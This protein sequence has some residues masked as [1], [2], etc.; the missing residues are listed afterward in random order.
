MTAE[1]GWSGVTMGAVADRAG[2]SRQTVHHE[3]GTK[4]GLAEAMVEHELARFLA[5]VATAFDDHPDDAVAG[6]RGASRGVLELARDN[7]LLVAVVSATHG[8]D[9][10]LLPLLTTRSESL[11][12]AAT[13]VVGERLSA[14][15]LG[16]EPERLDA[17]VDM[18]VN[19]TV[20]PSGGALATKSAAITP[21]APGLASTITDCP[22]RCCSFSA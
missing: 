10:E 7:P 14:Y 20:W 19:S 12:A 11:V 2:V 18:V 9:T 17:T 3:V 21:L 22:Q 15:R 13:A 8:A 16:L 6:I 4:H 5:V 1:T